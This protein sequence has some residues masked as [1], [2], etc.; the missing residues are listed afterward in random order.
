MTR[1]CGQAQLRIAS[2]L[3]SHNAFLARALDIE[4]IGIQ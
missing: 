2:P 1:S 3:A 4:R